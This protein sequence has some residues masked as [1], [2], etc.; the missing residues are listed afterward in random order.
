MKTIHG[1]SAL[2]ALICIF[3]CTRIGPLATNP[4]GAAQNALD[5][6]KAGMDDSTARV[7]GFRNAADGKNSRLGQPIRVYEMSC[8]AVMQVADSAERIDPT[9]MSE[10]EKFYFPLQ[11]A[12]GNNRS[13]IL[14]SRLKSDDG[15]GKKDLWSPVQV[16]AAPLMSQIDAALK[17]QPLE[18]IPSL[19]IAQTPALG[20]AFLGF[21][22]GGEF[23]LAP[24]ALFGGVDSCMNL[25]ARGK[26]RSA[27][28]MLAALS[29]CQDR[30]TACN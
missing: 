6:F 26:D 16:G 24:A 5:E 2:S 13:L 17:T 1:L 27:G 28:W 11:D 8:T 19:F 23:R 7:L 10:R 3:G 25:P 12:A 20:A 14:V 9:K 21:E 15:Y 18:R 4:K 30:K 29:R 22:A